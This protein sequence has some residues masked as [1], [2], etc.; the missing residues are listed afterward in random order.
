M[1][2]VRDASVCFQKVRPFIAL[3]NPLNGC[4][5]LFILLLY[6]HFI[7]NNV[8]RTLAFFC[9]HLPHFAF[10]S[11]GWHCAHCTRTWCCDCDSAWM[12]LKYYCKWSMNGQIPAFYIA[13]HIWC[14]IPE[15]VCVCVVVVVVQSVWRRNY[16]AT[17]IYWNIIWRPIR[18][19][20]TPHDRQQGWCEIHRFHGFWIWFGMQFGGEI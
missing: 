16:S 7:R 11:V 9:S 19:Y 3:N 4:V 8:I 18:F 15:C 14:N 6:F 17:P 20:F 5:E 1:E 13:L 10:C 2:L 12:I